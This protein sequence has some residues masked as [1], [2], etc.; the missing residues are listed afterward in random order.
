MSSGLGKDE[1][2]D[3]DAI[4]HRVTLFG[5]NFVTE[6][7]G[8][9]FWKL[10]Y[11]E[12][13]DPMLRVLIIAGIISIVTGAIQHPENGWVQQFPKRET[14]PQTGV[15]FCIVLRAGE[16]KKIPFGEVVVGDLVVLRDGFTIPADGIFVLALR[17]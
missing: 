6:K 8:I 10:C 17:T 9:P 16:E 15:K 1:I 14:V 4:Q 5:T 13:E 12:T 2:D 11:G 7:S 3:I